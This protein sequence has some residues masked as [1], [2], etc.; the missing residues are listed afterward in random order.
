M[1]VKPNL[2]DQLLAT[3][4]STISAEQRRRLDAYVETVRRCDAR[5]QRL[6]AELPSAFAIGHGAA[7]AVERDGDGMAAPDKAIAVFSELDT[8]ERVQ[9]RVDDWLKQYVATLTTRPYL[10]A[11]GDG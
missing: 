7:A 10:D 4:P 11:Y 3:V 2:I 5:I 1:R 8:L 6:R 9:P